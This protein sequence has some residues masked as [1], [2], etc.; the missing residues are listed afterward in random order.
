MQ[1]I[2]QEQQAEMV[3]TTTVLFKQVATRCQVKDGG[4]FWPTAISRAAGTWPMS[5]LP[6]TS[7][8]DAPSTHQTK[9]DIL[10]EL[11]RPRTTTT[12]PPLISEHQNNPRIEDLSENQDYSQ[13]TATATALAASS[14]PSSSPSPPVIYITWTDAWSHI[15]HNLQQT[16]HMVA[17]TVEERSGESPL[18]CAA[19]EQQQWLTEATLNT[20]DSTREWFRGSIVWPEVEVQRISALRYRIDWHGVTFPVLSSSK[21]N[22]NE[23]RLVADL[24]HTL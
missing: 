21:I 10:E 3:A 1:E 20:V 2:E 13:P 16:V 14:T 4:D 12:T 5:P 23:K 11:L 7:T 9:F 8:T 22:K 24:T 17:S 15:A 6:A 19:R 18:L